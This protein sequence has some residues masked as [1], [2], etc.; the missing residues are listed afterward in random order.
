MCH[1][2][3]RSDAGARVWRVYKDGSTKLDGT[4]DDYAFT[5]RAFL[6]LAEATME[7]AWWQRGADLVQAIRARFYE[8][9]DGVGIFYMTASDD[10]EPLIHRPESNSREMSAWL[11]S[12]CRLDSRESGRRVCSRRRAIR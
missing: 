12:R 9:R 7:P 10:S 6:D 1:G 4:I 5:A 11:L 2:D 3:A 8:E